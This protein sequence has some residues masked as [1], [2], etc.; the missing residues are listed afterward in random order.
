MTYEPQTAYA[1]EKSRKY[2]SSTEQKK[3]QELEYLV[4]DKPGE[5]FCDG[6]G[7]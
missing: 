6:A 3:E 2:E 5:W 7:I 1:E 4:Q